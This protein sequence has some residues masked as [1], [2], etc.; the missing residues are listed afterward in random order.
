[1]ILLGC[2]AIV[3]VDGVPLLMVHGHKAGARAY[4][5]VLLV[6][7]HTHPDEHHTY[8]LR[9]RSRRAKSPRV[10]RTDEI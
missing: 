3:L 9:E 2:E 6:M 5:E 8:E 10:I 7:G 4:A 1:M